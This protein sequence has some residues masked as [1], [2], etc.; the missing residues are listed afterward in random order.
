MS[1]VTKKHTK[2]GKKSSQIVKESSGHGAG[3]GRGGQ[4][5]SG[6]LFPKGTG[7]L[8]ENTTSLNSESQLPAWTRMEVLAF[9]MQNKRNTQNSQQLSMS[10]KMKT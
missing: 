3:A 7:C 8:E 10:A 1:L 4:G 2:G 5:E 6:S 9:I